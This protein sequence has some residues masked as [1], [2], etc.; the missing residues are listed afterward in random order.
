MDKQNPA[1]LLAE[2]SDDDAFFFERALRKACIPCSLVRARNGKIAIELLSGSSASALEPLLIFLDLK[3]PV[4]SGF[5]VLAWLASSP[6]ASKPKVFVLS[7]S[8]DQTDKE[9]ALA[10]GAAEYLVKPITSDSL[11]AKITEAL[12]ATNPFSLET[13]VVS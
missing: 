2:D 7:G 12:A 6:I 11:R 9:R 8:N 10:L 1:I 5:D 13:G 3:M 4:M